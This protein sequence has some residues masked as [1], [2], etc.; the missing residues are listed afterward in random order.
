M[1]NRISEKG[2]GFFLQEETTPFVMRL[3]TMALVGQND[4]FYLPLESVA[5]AV[6]IFDGA[7]HPTP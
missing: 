6:G 4:D 5:E 1:G 7:S 2:V 3:D